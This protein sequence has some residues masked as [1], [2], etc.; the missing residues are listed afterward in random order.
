MRRRASRRWPSSSAI[1]SRSPSKQPCSSRMRDAPTRSVAQRPSSRLSKPKSANRSSCA[2]ATA[3][4]CC[5]AASGCAVSQNCAR[6]TA[7]AAGML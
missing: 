1:R 5:A 4:I 2:A 3:R 7:V 6:A